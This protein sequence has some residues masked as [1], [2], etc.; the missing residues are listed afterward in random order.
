MFLDVY[1]QRS[2]ETFILKKNN[3][4]LSRPANYSLENTTTPG[5][6][7]INFT[8]PLSE[9]DVIEAYGY[10]YYQGWMYHYATLNGT[11]NVICN[12]IPGN[13]YPAIKWLDGMTS[14]SVDVYVNSTRK[15]SS[16]YT[17]ANNNGILEIIFNDNTTGYV[18]IKNKNPTI[19]DPPR[20]SWEYIDNPM[21][22]ELE[23]QAR[24]MIRIFNHEGGT[25][26]IRQGDSYYSDN[27]GLGIGFQ[28][29]GMFDPGVITPPP[30]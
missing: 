10:L 5:Y 1:P 15:N 13:N 20:T 28:L 23:K 27:W 25:I 21:Y 12:A 11:R 30:E 18:E 2:L 16:T 3:V 4:N 8:T 6:I 19:V 9:G 29:L 7:T 24:G 26:Y 14:Y 22:L 17:V